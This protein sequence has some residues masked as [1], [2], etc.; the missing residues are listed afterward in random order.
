MDGD[1]YGS[2]NDKIVLITE[3]DPSFTGI[4]RKQAVKNG[5][6]WSSQSPFHTEKIRISQPSK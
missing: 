2:A 5:F 3:D 4:L 6:K 1:A